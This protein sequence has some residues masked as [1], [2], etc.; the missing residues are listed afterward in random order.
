MKG[1]LLD[2]VL[3]LLLGSALQRQSDRNHAITMSAT[4][5]DCSGKRAWLAS[6]TIRVVT[7]SPHSSRSSLQVLYGLKGSLSAMICRMGAVPARLKAA[8]ICNAGAARAPRELAGLSACTAAFCMWSVSGYQP[9]SHGRALWLGAKKASLSAA[10]LS[11]YRP[12]QGS[13]P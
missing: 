11:C 6:A 10:S 5:G 4:I 7:R 3:D 1:Y 9:V 13:C 12:R 8:G 2:R